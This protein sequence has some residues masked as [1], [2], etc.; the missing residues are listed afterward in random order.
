MDK[1]VIRE[2]NL[3]ALKDRYP[4]VAERLMQYKSSDEIVPFVSDVCGRDVLALEYKG[5]LLL[6]DTT[7]D[8]KKYLNDWFETVNIPDA[9]FGKIVLFGLG[10]GMYARK[11][12]KSIPDDFLILVEEPSVE[13]F[14]TVMDCIDISD[15]L[16][17]ERITIHFGFDKETNIRPY[18][19]NRINYEDYS[20]LMLLNYP[21]YGTIYKNEWAELYNVLQSVLIRKH[22][23]LYYYKNAGKGVVNNEIR[24]IN[25]YLNSFALSDLIESI[26]SDIPAFVVACGPSLRKNVAKLKRAVGKSIIIATDSALNVMYEQGIVPDV[27]LAVDPIKDRKYMAFEGLRHVPMIVSTSTNHDIIE[28]HLGKKI[29]YSVWGYVYLQ[30]KEMGKRVPTLD[31]GGSV[32]N[33]AL[34]LAHLMGCKNIVLIGQDLA[35]T[36]NKTHSD[37]S[38]RGNAKEEIE[39]AIWDVDIY[40]NKI[41]TSQMF[42]MFKEWI[43]DTIAAKKDIKVIDATEGG[44]LIKGAEICTLDEAIDKYCVKE[45]SCKEVFEKVGK[46]FSAEEKKQ[47]ENN[48]R[49]LPNTYKEITDTLNLLNSRY[50]KMAEMITNDN[51]RCN[52]F[53]ELSRGA[54]EILDKVESN[55]SIEYLQNLV[56]SDYIEM[57]KSVNLIEKDEKLE[58]ESVVEMSK[59]QVKTLKKGIEMFAP[60]LQ[61]MINELDKE[62][63]D[64]E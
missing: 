58:L 6:L 20:S 52:E 22:S 29:F 38:V 18:Y 48:V 55:P 47:F 3:E 15:I 32:A 59:N 12:S 27:A 36:D 57:L 21:N 25:D 62:G 43:E 54:N 64:N 5:N 60:L 17:D 61:I 35:Y 40:G 51:Y 24:N 63:E 28:Y 46:L 44:I 30:T 39:D 45:Y 19:E 56:Q 8:S 4:N 1:N 14:R 9:I 16:K 34:S 50:D 26:D 2:K 7:Y 10:N 42:V 13:I 41:Q 31:T 33:N 23:D 49:N 11:L 53:I 37:G